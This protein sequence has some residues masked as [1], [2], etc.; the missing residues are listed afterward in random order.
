MTQPRD[1]YR[2]IVK[3]TKCGKITYLVAAGVPLNPESFKAGDR[4]R[5]HVRRVGN[6]KDIYDLENYR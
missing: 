6:R 4:I 1:S 5:V 2:S 3:A